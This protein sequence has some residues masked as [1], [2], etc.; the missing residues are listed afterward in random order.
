MG[1][2]LPHLPP[3]VLSAIK[4]KGLIRWQ[5]ANLSFMPQSHAFGTASSRPQSQNEAVLDPHIT[6][7]E[8]ALPKSKEETL[9]KALPK[10]QGETLEKALTESYKGTPEEAPPDPIINYSIN[11]LL[12]TEPITD[13]SRKSLRKAFLE[14]PI[15]TGALYNEP[16]QST[17]LQ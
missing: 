13:D 16:C 12:L 17:H 1:A 8:Q 5:S 9:E 15:T 6:I 2:H 4:G 10:S 14:S 11:S 3:T 7:L